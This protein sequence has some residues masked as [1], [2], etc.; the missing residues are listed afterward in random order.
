[1]TVL[2]KT[3]KECNRTDPIAYANCEYDRLCFIL[4]PLRVKINL[5]PRPQNKILVPFRGHFQKIRRAPPS[6]LYGSPPP[7]AVI[8]P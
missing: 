6:L 2:S 7:G 1:M 3:W 8:A 4:I 5:G